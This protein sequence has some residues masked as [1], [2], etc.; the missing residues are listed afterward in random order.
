MVDSIYRT[1]LKTLR[2]TLIVVFITGS[3]IYYIT[4]DI[5]HS[6]GY[7]I[8]IELIEIL[9]YYVNERLW[10]RIWI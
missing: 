10:N 2:W 9:V 5:L 7:A 6:S 4:G 8:T 1:I 3:I